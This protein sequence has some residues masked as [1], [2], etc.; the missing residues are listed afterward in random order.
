M[1][2]VLKKIFYLM[3]LFIKDYLLMIFILLLDKI[4]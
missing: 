3:M 2:F 1:Y 4:N